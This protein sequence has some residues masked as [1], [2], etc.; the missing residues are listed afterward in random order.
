MRYRT[1]ASVGLV[2]LPA[3]IQWPSSAAH[4]V[5]CTS[6]RAPSKLRR[7]PG[8]CVV[9][10]ANGAVELLVVAAA[11]ARFAA[12]GAVLASVVLLQAVMASPPATANAMSFLTGAPSQ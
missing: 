12:T 3:A 5:S 1:A 11:P 8:A 9:S 4:E 6:T 2:A 7:L 10:D